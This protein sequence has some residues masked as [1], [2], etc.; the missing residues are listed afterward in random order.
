MHRHAGKYGKHIYEILQPNRFCDFASK[1]RFVWVY[2][3]WKHVI[4]FFGTIC[5]S[6]LTMPA[7]KK[8]PVTEVTGLRDALTG[9]AGLAWVT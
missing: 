6:N 9:L 1:N 8:N 5:D 7:T 4:V 2:P 3:L